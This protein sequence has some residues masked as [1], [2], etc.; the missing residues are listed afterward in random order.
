MQ[1][2]VV[3]KVLVKAGL[4]RDGSSS[5]YKVEVNGSRS[6]VH[7]NPPRS[8]RNRL[9]SVVQSD[10]LKSSYIGDMHLAMLRAPIPRSGA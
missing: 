1:S 9:F 10:P 5:D 6:S 7:C 3:V 8:L 4:L 2:G